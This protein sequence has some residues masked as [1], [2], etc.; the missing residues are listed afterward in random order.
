MTL[1]LR[2]APKD[3]NEYLKDLQQIFNPVPFKTVFLRI[4]S[5]DDTIQMTQALTGVSKIEI[6]VFIL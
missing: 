4:N 3:Y 1:Q 2:N 6:K 5:W